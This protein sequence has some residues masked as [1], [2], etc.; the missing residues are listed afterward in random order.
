[1]FPNSFYEDDITLI[2]NPNKENTQIE[3][4][5]PISLIAIDTK[6]LN[7][8]LAN[9]I[10]KLN[11]IIHLKDQMCNQVRFIPGIQGW[12]NGCKSIRIHYINK[13]KDKNHMIISI[14]AEKA[15]DKINL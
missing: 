11:T 8:I 3:N 9:C 5:R 6:I 14:V 2:S 7:K 10:Y 4:Y 15:I 13:V 12:F 1:M